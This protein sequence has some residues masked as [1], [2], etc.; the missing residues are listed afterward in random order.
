MGMILLFFAI[1]PGFLIGG[2][3]SATVWS[4]FRNRENAKKSTVVIETL[5]AGFV[6]GVI[7]TFVAAQLMA[8][9]MLAS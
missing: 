4:V 9:T 5:A 8:K 6:G 3:I 7:C 1:I 2:T